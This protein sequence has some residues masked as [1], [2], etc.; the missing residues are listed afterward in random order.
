LEQAKPTVQVGICG[1]RPRLR[2][3]LGEKGL[4]YLGGQF[5]LVSLAHL[6]FD[7]FL[8]LRL[9]VRGNKVL[10]VGRREVSKE[11]EPGL[12]QRHVG[13]GSQ[14]FHDLASDRVAWRAAISKTVIMRTSKP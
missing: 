11:A 13:R 2:E 7:G 14:V 8:P 4:D 5:A 10:Q 3:H 1:T 12:R 6:C 9:L